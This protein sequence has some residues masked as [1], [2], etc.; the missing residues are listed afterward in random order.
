MN[1]E[2]VYQ[3]DSF[4]DSDGEPK[5]FNDSNGVPKEFNGSNRGTTRFIID[6]INFMGKL[7]ATRFVYTSIRHH[8]LSYPYAY[9]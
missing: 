4:D 2:V 9:N 1:L 7:H 3:S 5:D 8:V 6:I